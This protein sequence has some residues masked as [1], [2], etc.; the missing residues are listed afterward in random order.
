MLDAYNLEVLPGE[1]LQ[2]QS[3]IDGKFIEP[4]SGRYLDNIQPAI[5]KPYSHV[6][7]SATAAIMLQKSRVLSRALS[8]FQRDLLPAIAHG[9]DRAVAIG[10]RPGRDALPSRVLSWRTVHYRGRPKFR[11]LPHRLS[12][13]QFDP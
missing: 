5:G 6:A 9:N 8:A 2:I 10:R 1:T 3:F 4:L 12:L 13:I 7:M 11:S